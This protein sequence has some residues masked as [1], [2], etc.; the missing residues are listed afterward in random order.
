M[1]ILL[2]D[3]N[4]TENVKGVSLVHF[5]DPAPAEGKR[6]ENICEMFG[7]KNKSFLS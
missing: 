2:N 3:T 1:E 5:S 6:S 4:E 7:L